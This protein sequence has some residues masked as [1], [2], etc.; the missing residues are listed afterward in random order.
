MRNHRTPAIH[1]DTSSSGFRKTRL[2]GVHDSDELRQNETQGAVGGNAHSR[3]PA[4]DG[5]TFGRARALDHDVGIL[6]RQVESLF[7]HQL[8]I[9]WDAGIDL[10]GQVAATVP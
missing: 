6:G 4:Q 3:Q 7:E 1:I 9:E 2:N 10:A 5:D 8:F